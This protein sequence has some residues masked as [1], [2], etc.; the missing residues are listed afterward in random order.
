[1]DKKRIKFVDQDGLE[2]VLLP[3]LSKHYE[4]EISDNLDY[5]FY[6]NFGKEH[7]KYDCIK[8]FSTGECVIPNFNEC[9]YATGF[10]YLEFG[11][12]YLRLP[13][14]SSM[15]RNGKSVLELANNRGKDL[16][17]IKEKK[18]C[19][20]VVSNGNGMYSREA[21]FNLLNTYKKVDSG[22]SY[23]NNVGYKVIDKRLFE[24]EYKFSLTFE[25]CRYPGYT[26]EKISDAFSSGAIP[27]YFGDPLVSK[28]FNPKAFINVCDFKDFNDAFEY[29]KKVDNDDELYNSI[30][31]EP[32]YINKPNGL[33]EFEKFVCHILDEDISKALRR[34][35]SFYAY[36]VERNLKNYDS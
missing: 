9:D 26:T 36:D 27:I 32:I 19:S 18:F 22:G 30:I 12:R 11:D 35:R 1:M 4:I 16:P 17:I 3:I 24:H 6:S 13:L 15:I 7:L 29:I 14:C 2:D 33:D 25:N 8:I 28:I 31:N 23:L 10:D 34:P 5:L 20:F 21:M